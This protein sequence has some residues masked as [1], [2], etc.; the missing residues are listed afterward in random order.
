MARSLLTPLARFAPLA[1]AAAACAV[2]TNAERSA[3]ETSPF[4][5]PNATLV[6]FDFDGELTHTAAA[7]TTNAIDTQL[8]FLVGNLNG[9]GGVPRL[10]KASLTH[11]T[12]TSIGGGLAD[13]HYHVSIPVAYGD[14]ANPPSTFALTLPRHIESSGESAFLA[15]YATTCDDGETT[16]DAA[17]FWYHFRPNAAGCSFA[18][19]DVITPRATVGVSPQNTSGK[20]P[21]LHK[22][23][24]DR[25]F[26]VV[27]VFAKYAVGA[28]TEDDAGIAAYDQFIAGLQQTFPDAMTTPAALPA[29]PG[30]AAPDV[31]FST[32]LDDG[33]NVT[34]TA[35]LVDSVPSAGAKFVARYGELTPGADLVVYAGHAGLG[36]NVRALAAEGHWFPGKYQVVFLDGCDTFAYMDAA[37]TLKNARASL[38]PDDPN[39]TKY[40]DVITNAMPAFFASMPSAALAVLRGLLNDAQPQTYDDI[41]GAIDP[42][43]IAVVTGE[44]DNVYVPGYSTG[45]TYAGFVASGSVTKGQII[46][47]ETGVLPAGKYEFEMTADAIHPG[48]D[49]D[50]RVRA[51]APPGTSLTWKCPSYVRNTNERCALTL[52]APANVY[53]TAT[54]DSSTQASW[55]VVRGWQL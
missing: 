15:K 1:L 11:V 32:L 29:G 53:L 5:S 55:F 54:G 25:S 18:P 6:Q 10:D 47:Y 50:L 12:V 41:L 22:V 9:V 2:P 51:G 40:M 13:V 30:V 20:Y 36:A 52:S 17:N 16:P 8:L 42:S 4:S 21:E 39:G 27:A 44:E 45:A 7:S 46:P 26:N 34:V 48:G 33:R 28:T 37:T 14:K 31:T 3:G 38:N 35:L 49:G 19:D 24:E 23:W 43:Q